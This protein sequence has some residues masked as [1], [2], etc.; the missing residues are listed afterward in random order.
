MKSKPDNARFPFPFSF[1]FLEV[2]S[3]NFGW[4][5]IVADTP[6]GRMIQCASTS[7]DFEEG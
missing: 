4:A 7:L 2:G 5:G 1:V 3:E 6:D